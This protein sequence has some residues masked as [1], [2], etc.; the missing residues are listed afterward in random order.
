[1]NFLL[2]EVARATLRLADAGVPSPRTDAEEL[3]AYVHGVRR[4]QLHEVADS[5]FDALYWECVARRAARE[6]LQH[7]TG[8]AYFRYLELRVGPGVFVPRPETEIMV[9]WA[10]QTLRAMDVADPLVA[11]L[12][13]GSGAI[14]I[15]IAQ[16]VPRSRVHAVDIDPEALGWA[17]RNIEASGHADRVHAHQGDMRTALPDLD[18]RLDLLIS[19]PPY[20]P[21]TD[22]A[23]LPPEVRD[24]DPAPALWAG[25]DGLDL[26]RSLEAVGR[27]LLRPGGAMAIEHGDGQ[28]IDIPRLFPEELGW[29]DVRNRKDLAHRDRFVVMRRAED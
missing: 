20:V 23:V 24:H 13:T 28:G 15:S 27:R 25:R 2:D 19:N 16:E 8:R 1:M 17:R 6:P 14:A 21:T 29:R 18:G 4:G 11:D 26:I 12:G 7:I 3:A 10:I 22:S 5:D 9:D